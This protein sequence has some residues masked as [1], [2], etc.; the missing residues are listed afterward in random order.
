MILDSKAFDFSKFGLT[1]FPLE[2]DDIFFLDDISWIATK[3][4]YLNIFNLGML[5]S[6]DSRNNWSVDLYFRLMERVNKLKQTEAKPFRRCR[7][8]EFVFHI[9][10][11]SALEPRMSKNK[12]NYKCSKSHFFLE[13]IDY[14]K[15]FHVS[16]G[17]KVLEC[18]F[19][20]LA[21]N[22]KN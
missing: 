5:I 9:F 21:D 2:G 12:Y 1:S 10:L 13:I 11:Y 6:P 15:K 19:P 18:F 3:K 14:L 16:N 17:L 7:E 4:M 22:L 20:L 8:L